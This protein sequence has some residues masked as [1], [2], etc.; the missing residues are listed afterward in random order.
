LDAANRLAPGKVYQ[1]LS[2]VGYPQEVANAMSYVFSDTLVCTDADSAKK[3]TFSAE[4]A[5]RSVTLEGDVY[6][7]SGSLTGGAAPSGSGILIKAQELMEVGG[8]LETA[9]RMLD[10][11]E[12]EGE[13]KKQAREEWR[14]LKRELEMKEHEGK[15]MEEQVGGSNAA[16]VSIFSDEFLACS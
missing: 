5:V 4:V 6:D 3:V 15:L 16:R 12:K 7:P 14:R 13:R 10:G 1:A 2:L 8:R 9:R 11:L